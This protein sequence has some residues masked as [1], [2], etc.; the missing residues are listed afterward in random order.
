MARDL[1][2]VLDAILAGV[3]VLDAK[4]TV[5]QLNS[6]ACRILEHSAHAAVGAPVERLLGP[7]HALARLGR[8][9]L[10]T[11]TPASENSQEI[12]SRFNEDLKVDVV[13]SPLFDE[14]GL[15]DGVVLVL[16]DRSAQR[17]L[18]QLEAERERMDFFG[19]IAAGMAHEVKNP[20]GGIRGAG[21]L[22]SQ[23]A[24]NDKTRET[25]DLIV[26]ESARIAKLVDEFMVF[27]RGD[28]LRLKASNLHRILDQVIDLLAH[29]PLSR[30]CSVVRAYDPSIPELLTDADRLTQVFLNLT[31]NAFQ[32]MRN[33]GGRLTIITRV[34]LDHRVLTES[35]R[36]LPT[37]ATWIQDTGPGM[38][39]EDLRQATIPFFTTRS[40]GTGLGLSV[41]EYW[42]SQHGGTL[43]IESAPG[44]GT[45]VRVTLPLRREA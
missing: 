38:S 29:D 36:L 7:D 20:L 31:R 41:A 30:D 39:E 21:E 13:A 19:R 42:V 22:L 2:D 34:T 45:A 27:A 18:E 8:R 1:R 40:D 16:R 14:T 17:R 25:A 23:R 6:A 43:R 44:E 35:G 10:E 5:E 24:E 12:E 15:L 32:A 4:G 9:V 37:V 26:R 11:A 33:G 3:V 28:R